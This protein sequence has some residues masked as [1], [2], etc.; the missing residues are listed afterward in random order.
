MKCS[1]SSGLSRRASGRRS[2]WRARGPRRGLR[3]PAAAAQ[4]PRAGRITRS[5]REGMKRR[6]LQRMPQRQYLHPRRR[7]RPARMPQRRYRKSRGRGGPAIGRKAGRGIPADAAARRACRRGGT[8]RAAAAASPRRPRRA[9]AAVMQRMTVRQGAGAAPVDALGLLHLAAVAAA[10]VPG[11]ASA[12]TDD[13]A[14]T[15]ASTAQ[16]RHPPPPAPLLLRRR[17]AL[18][19]AC[20]G[21]AEPD[22]RGLARRT[23]WTIGRQRDNASPWPAIERSV[24][25]GL[26]SG[27]DIR[28]CCQGDR[29]A[30]APRPAARRL[31]A[32]R[33]P[34][35]GSW[36]RHLPGRRCATCPAGGGGKEGA[37]EHSL[38]LSP[39][40]PPRP[41]FSKYMGAHTGRDR[42][43][44]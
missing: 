1:R 28:P 40:L 34:T 25:R 22:S 5:Q 14:C 9:A 33:I 8:E 27:D 39:L 16:S 30:A 32:G 17:A 10:A 20:R 19:A 41:A 31:P 38:P 37:P 2:G 13:K 36:I 29:Y 42:G 43:A 44:P 11:T 6:R 15:T 21:A 3:P 12:A 24:A 35:T 4:C 18:P 26:A 23:W 7:R